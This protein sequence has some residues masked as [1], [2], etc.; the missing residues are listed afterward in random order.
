MSQSDWQELYKAALLELDR[1][2]LPVRVDAARNAMRSRL[3]NER[4]SLGKREFDD[5]Q[6]ALRMLSVLLKTAA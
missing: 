1:A 5:I 6:S 4:E 2:L 3:A